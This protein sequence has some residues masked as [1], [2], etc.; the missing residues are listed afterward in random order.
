[1][2]ELLARLQAALS[3]RYRIER[4]LGAGGMA[5]VFLA[6]DLKHDR[7]VALKVLHPEIAAALGPQRFLREIRTTAALE[8]P[9]ILPVFDSG[10]ASGQLWYTMPHIDG[11]SLRDRLRREGQLPTEEALRLACE[12]ADALDYAHRHGV[13]HRDVKPENLLLSEGHARIADFG[14]AQAIESAGEEHLTGTGVAIGTPSYMSPEQAS[15]GPVDARTDIY[16]LGCVLYEM[17]AGEPPFTGATPQ[18]ILAKR[19]IQTATPLRQLRETIPAHVDE[20]VQRALA[21]VPADRFATAAEFCRSLATPARPRGLSRAAMRRLL[22]GLAGGLAVAAL[23]WRAKADTPVLDSNLVAVAP[24]DVFSPQLELW[25]EGLVD[26]LSR[27]LDGAGPL[28]TVPP[29]LVIRRWKGRADRTAAT[30]LGHDTGAGLA[31]YGAVLASGPD[32]VRLTASVLDVERGQEVGEL[33]LRGPV[34]RVD[35]LADSLA[36]SVLRELG[37]TRPIGAAR[38]SGLGARSLPALKAFLRGESH[39]RRAEWDSARVLYER[40]IA[41]DSAFALAYWRLGTVAWWQ[42]D[43]G[44]SLHQMY[45]LKAGALNHGLPPRESLLIA[46]ESLQTMV[47]ASIRDSTAREQLRR[48]YK[49]TELVTRQYPSDPEAWV[50][51]AEARVHGLGVSDSMKHAAIR[52]AIELDSAYA[53]A[54]AHAIELALITGDWDA[55]RRYSARFLVLRP[56]DDNLVVARAIP[57][58]IDPA[59][60]AARIDQFLDSVSVGALLGIWTSFLEVPEHREIAVEAARR[61]ATRRT[62]ENWWFGDDSIPWWTVHLGGTLIQRG[63]FREAVPLV[64][65]HK[66]STAGFLLSELAL[67]GAIPADSADAFYRRQ[68]TKRPFQRSLGLLF[69]PP[70]WAA[71]GDTTALRQYIEFTRRDQQRQAAAPP[72]DENDAVHAFIT[73]PGWLAA[74]EA[75]LALARRDT[76]AA[77]ARFAA[78]PDTTG[79]VWLERLTLARLLVARGQ[80]RSA[81][82]VLDREFPA[83]GYS[84][85]RVPWALERARLAERLGERGKARNWYAYVAK[86]WQRAD[87]ELQPYVAEARA[88]LQRFAAEGDG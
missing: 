83:N 21:R 3:G 32:S 7:S 62:S 12:V 16:A 68:L 41:L 82:A 25:R 64:S 42:G 58:L 51:L 60:S 50:A 26:L 8:H 14:L 77:L 48:L 10:E 35:Q 81:L 63:H 24:F 73:A 1:M 72:Q 84:G 17:L 55:A 53:P 70:W 45:A 13:V 69:A 44:D 5:A 80:D 29:S 79:F 9:H 78:L 87:P 19:F 39:F 38:S 6:H 52:Q 65:S 33:E 76:A 30:G 15:A 28:R 59:P 85:S 71:R 67:A 66:E 46:C 57:L 11:G 49:S 56:K 43:V 22:V 47:N 74:A 27:H 36:L 20:A 18:A 34:D 31:V 4:Q 40:V 88:A 86:M 2:S 61:L 23:L 54:Y 75:Y 37:R